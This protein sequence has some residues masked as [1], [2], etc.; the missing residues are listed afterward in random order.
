MKNKVD[1]FI[2][3]LA[4][5]A[6]QD[7]NKIEIRDMEKNNTVKKTVGLVTDGSKS[8]SIAIDN[9]NGDEDVDEVYEYMLHANNV[10][11][12]IDWDI[13]K[14]IFRLVNYEANKKRLQNSPHRKILDLCVEYTM[15]VSIEG[16]DGEASLRITNEVA[17]RLGKTEEELFEIA[18]RN[19][20]NLYPSVVRVL[21]PLGPI[22]IMACR[23]IFGTDFLDRAPMLILSNK[24]M[25][26]GASVILYEGELDRMME[27]LGVDEICVIPSSVDEVIVAP[28]EALDF[29]LE[30]ISMVNVT[31]LQP[32]KRLSNNAYR[33]DGE[34]HLVKSSNPTLSVTA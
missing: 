14:I 19:T 27:Q 18:K 16:I 26:F 9:F 12:D 28:V 17:E 21:S 32:E 24:Q 4:E 7:G 1:T 13:N 20:Q 25:N 3:K 15:N 34:L 30:D 33:Y 10:D 11:I 8:S 2:K 31:S 22:P 29:L 6:M 5:R 23:E